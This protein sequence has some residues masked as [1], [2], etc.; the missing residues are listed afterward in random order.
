MKKIEAQDAVKIKYSMKSHLR[1]GTVKKRPEETLGFI[2]KVEPQAPTLED[3]LEGGS[4]GDRFTIQV[5]ASELYGEYNP[6][7]VKEI[8]KQGLIKQRVKE[9]Q[10]YRQMKEGCLVSF[11]ILEVKEDT[12]LADFNEPM[13][14]IWVEMSVEVLEVREVDTEELETARQRQAKKEI[15]CG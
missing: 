14:G 9:D 6:A 3:A 2:Y 15:G 13:A 7:L 8:P 12:V 10:Y 5:P 1:D 11:K 4:V